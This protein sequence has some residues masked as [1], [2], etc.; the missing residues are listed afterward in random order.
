MRALVKTA[1]G[2]GNVEIRDVPIPEIGRDD[3]L[4]KVALCGICG[5][6]IH[7]QDGIH[8]CEAPVTLGH[9]YVGTVAKAGRNVKDLKEGDQVA[10]FSSPNP[11]PGYRVDGAHAEYMRVGAKYLWKIPEGVTLE[12][13][14]QFETVRVPM[15]LVRDTVQLRPGE[16]IVISGPGPVGLMAVNMAKIEGASHI[17]VLG[18][19]GDEKMRLP[20]ALE[21]GADVAEPFS[22]EAVAKLQGD[23]APRCWI[24]ASGAAVAIEAAVESVSYGG[25]VAV[26]G[27][28][29]GPWNVNMWRVARRNLLVKGQWGGREEYVGQS[30]DLI[31]SGKLKMDSLITATVPLTEWEKAFD[32]LR[33]KEGIKILLDPTK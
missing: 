20:K 4:M 3:V 11:F 33:M 18:G 21:L 12:A 27:I 16:R 9:E 31:R 5:S 14:T 8:E 17:T 32:L 30:V 1:Q 29:K 19:P 2:V 22:D 24:E 6:D 7:I 10:F 13:A 26:S 28:G 25:R 23:G 15:G